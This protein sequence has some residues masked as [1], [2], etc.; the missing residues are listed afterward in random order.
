MSPANKKRCGRR[1][2]SAP[3]STAVGIV[4]FNAVRLVLMG[5]ALSAA[6]IIDDS[7]I[8]DP[9]IRVVLR[10]GWGFVAEDLS[11]RAEVVDHLKRRTVGSRK[12]DFERR[13]RGRL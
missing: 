2:L 6:R 10:D 12:V 11:G 3:D 4:G 7:A 8:A 1:V 9:R 5:Q 13:Q